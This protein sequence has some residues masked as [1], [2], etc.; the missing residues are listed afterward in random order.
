MPLI[1]RDEKYFD[2]LNQ[3]V[4]GIH[5]GADALRRLFDD[6]PHKADYLKQIKEIEHECDHISGGIIDRLNAAFITP[7]DREDIYLLATE[8]DDVMDRINDIA[9]LTVLYGIDVC[10]QPAK[11]LAMILMDVALELE[12]AVTALRTR[13]GVRDH[14]ERIK[15]LEEDGDRVWQSA[16]Q[17]LFAEEKN[18]IDLVRWMG[19]YEKL[20][21]GID[22]CKHVAK[23]LD[24]V[25]VKNA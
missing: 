14:I 17:R 21:A 6:V 10:T 2:L 18:P 19:I 4:A 23:T 15:S 1:P 9:L 16:V 8:L 13:S 22:Q 25:V 20:E 7:L 12:P 3:L 5:R 11:E 24:A